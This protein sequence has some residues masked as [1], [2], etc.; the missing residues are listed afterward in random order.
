MSEYE[1]NTASIS[2]ILKIG[3]CFGLFSLLRKA[4]TTQNRNYQESFICESICSCRITPTGDISE[5]YRWR[6]NIRRVYTSISRVYEL[7]SGLSSPL[8]ILSK[9]VSFV[10]VHSSCRLTLTWNISECCRWCP[11]SRRTPPEFR[12]LKSLSEVD[13]KE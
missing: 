4:T 9:K 12:R 2:E 8:E 1:T 7:E 11:N 5:C 10:T 3:E 6:S 13:Q